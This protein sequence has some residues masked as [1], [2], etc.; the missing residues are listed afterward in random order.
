MDESFASLVYAIVRQ[1]PEGKVSTYGQIALLVGKPRAA[2]VIGG[3][4]S[5][6][7]D[8][9]HV[10]CHRIVKHNGALC[11]G[12]TFGHLQNEL[13]HREGVAFLPDGRVDL[14]ASCWV[15]PKT[16]L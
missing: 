9:E 13:L 1:I 6:C 11:E 7:P 16:N 15:M 12:Y 10:P 4:M 3:I 5:R 14:K 8:S 2:R